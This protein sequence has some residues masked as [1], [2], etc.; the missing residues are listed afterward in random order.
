MTRRSRGHAPLIYLKTRS[1]KHAT[2]ISALHI[3][4]SE[5]SEPSRPPWKIATGQGAAPWPVA[6]IP[7]PSGGTLHALVRQRYWVADRRLGFELVD[8][9]QAYELG[10][11]K[12]TSMEWTT[13]VGALRQLTGRLVP[14]PPGITHG[15][16]RGVG[17]RKEYPHQPAPGVIDNRGVHARYLQRRRLIV[18]AK[19]EPPP[20]YGGRRLDAVANHV[21]IPNALEIVARMVGVGGRDTAG[22]APGPRS[23]AP[24]ISSWEPII[25]SLA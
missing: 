16:G 23:F 17:G 21:D 4:W 15:E 24:V 13:G 18:P 5:P 6:L 19:L 11:N 3:T 9:E 1:Q 12:G 22:V 10:S 20:A 8:V 14:E 7:R 2:V 25:L